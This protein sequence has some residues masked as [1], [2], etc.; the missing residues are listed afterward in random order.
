M[1]GK[2]TFAV[3]LVLGLSLVLASSL[4]LAQGQA[5]E[6]SAQPQAALGTAFT[7][8]GFLTDGGR[9]A[10]G[11]Y[12]LR[13]RLF[14]QLEDGAWLGDVVT[15]ENK[16]VSD[17]LFTV[18]LDFGGYPLLFDGAARY[19]EIAVRPGA[20]T[21]AFTILKPRQAL[22]PVPYALA[23]PAL[24]T[25]YHDITPN[26]VGGNLANSVASGAYG[27]TIGG[28]GTDYLP[29]TATARWSTIGGGLGNT[30]GSEATVSGGEK[31]TAS[32]VYATIGGGLENTAGGSL[33]TVAGGGFNEAQG[34]YAMV[35]GGRS[36]SAAGDYSFAAGYRAK[37][38]PAAQGAFV[39]SDSNEYD[40]IAWGPNEFVAR[41]TGGFWL[42]SGLTAEGLIGSGAHL[43]AGSNQWVW[44]SSRDA[45]TA[46]APVDGRDV[47]ARLARLPIE[48][49]SY[50]TQP[51]TIRHMGP[52]AQDFYA[53]FGLGEDEAYIGT[54]DANG[55]ALA[56]IQGLYQLSQEQA[57][58]IGELEAQNAS[59]EA[60]LAALESVVAELAGDSAGGAP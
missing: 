25:E 26:V 40:T 41:A 52:M 54:L 55:V 53:A 23:L 21:G 37:T 46:F 51:D 29:N 56:A 34:H 36:N 50:K 27:A 13:F 9:P 3:L 44:A 8:Q 45:K 2:H 60:R 15:R 28:G 11:K 30:T 33:A 12:D 39:W 18:Q 7:F 42:I 5:P 32:G 59:L 17:G 1:K 20:S 57:T 6:G 19:V 31:N 10:N 47:A 16:Q 43:P 58:R 24:R 35:P 14:D 22:T 38:K 49:W 48:T 4:G